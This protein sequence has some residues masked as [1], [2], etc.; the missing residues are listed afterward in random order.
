[1]APN[2]DTM[3]RL[4]SGTKALTDTKGKLISTNIYLAT[5]DTNANW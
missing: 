1:M 5:V 3:N 2:A 4:P